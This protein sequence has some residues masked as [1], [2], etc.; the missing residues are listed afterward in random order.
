VN[1]GFWL[2]EPDIDAVTR[3]ATPVESVGF[4]RAQ[5]FALVPH[6]WSPFN[7]Q[8][9]ALHRDVIPA[10]FLSPLIG[11]YDDIWASYVVDVIAGHL[12]DLI[13]FGHPL[14]RQDRNPHDWWTDLEHEKAGMQLTDRLVRYLRALTLTGTTYPACFAEVMAGLGRMIESDDAL[15][16]RGRW[17]LQGFVDGLQV[18]QATMTHAGRLRDVAT[19]ARA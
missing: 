3:L 13:A 18:W 16:G 17:H 4:P 1:A 15:D 14:V 6:T 12:G 8:N 2:G 10:Y 5:N 19:S 11:R 9:T 7:S